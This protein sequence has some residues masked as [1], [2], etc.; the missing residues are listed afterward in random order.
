[1]VP[2]KLPSQLESDEDNL[3]EPGRDSTIDAH[4]LGN[5]CSEPL[6]I[7]FT[8]MICSLPHFRQCTLVTVVRLGL[9]MNLLL[10]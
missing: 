3:E 7:A 4:E 8:I 10:C 1:M 2:G 5:G 9:T 6:S